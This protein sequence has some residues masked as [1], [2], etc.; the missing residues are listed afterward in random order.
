MAASCFSARRAFINFFDHLLLLVIVIG[1]RNMVLCDN[2]NKNFGFV[3]TRG[4]H[5]I[6][7]GSPFVFNGFNSYWMMH[8]ASDPSERY[9][10]SEVFKEAS[11]AGL[12]VCRTWAFSDGGDRPLQISPGIYD[13]R[14]FQGLDFVISEARKY[15]IRLIL[16][17]VNNYDDFGGKKQYA[18]WARN[19]GQQINN[20]DDFYTHPLLKDYY[21]NHI[22]S[23]VTRLNT[24]T[25]IA[26]RDDPIIMAWELMNEPRCQADYSGKT[27]NFWVQE[28]ASFIKSLDRK[29]LVEIGMEGFYGDTMPERKQVNPGYQV[30]TDFISNNLV[31]Q[32]DFATIHAYPDVWLSGKSENEQMGFMEKW[33]LSHFDDSR[34]I[35]KKP[36]IVA[37]F[38]KSDKD[39]GFSL[40]ERDLYM[41]NV[42]RD[43]YRFA[44]L[45]GGTLSGCLVWQIMAQGMDSYD[46]GYQI[47]L[48]QSPSTTGIISKQSHAMSAL[49]H[50]LNG[51][52][53]VDRVNGANEIPSGHHHHRRHANRHYAGHTR[54]T[55]YVKNEPA[56]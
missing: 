14:V 44:R 43:T 54:P 9:K 48:S 13:E 41:A 17:F 37:E 28:M 15:G 2:L 36:L 46:D 49:S 19:A 55:R 45:T 53:S 27:I 35:L 11:A 31:P 50:L 38:G 16:S 23:V 21:K 3:R 39:P 51:P 4:P 52:H 12:T 33:M 32:V 7:N 25:N 34:R 18:A 40:N 20:D 56:P 6:L 5:F 1:G 26:Y 10:V 24:I 42:Y 47:V 29:H 8:L 22:K 30:G